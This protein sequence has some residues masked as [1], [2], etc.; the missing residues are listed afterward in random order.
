MKRGTAGPGRTLARAF[1][2]VALLALGAQAASLGWMKGETGR[3]FTDRD[4]E[5][6]GETLQATLDG[7]PDGETREW[8]NGKSGARGSMT[9]LSTETR[10]DVTCRRLRVESVAKGSSSSHSYLFCR[11][12]DGSW[13]IGE[14]AG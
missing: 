5:L 6:V 14:P 2:L 11:R 3:Y 10:D 12:G 4:W 8:S 13:R 7:A 1:P 9:P